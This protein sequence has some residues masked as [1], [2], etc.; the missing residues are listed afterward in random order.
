MQ[1]ARPDMSLRHG[2]DFHCGVSPSQYSASAMGVALSWGSWSSLR[3]GC[4]TTGKA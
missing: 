1:L 2:S 4:H 3:Q